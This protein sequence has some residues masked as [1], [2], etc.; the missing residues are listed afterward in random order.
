MIST[1]M[2]SSRTCQDELLFKYGSAKDTKLFPL[3]AWPAEAEAPTGCIDCDCFKGKSVRE[4]LC[5]SPADTPAYY[6]V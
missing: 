5:V 6:E 2:S 3:L 1:C 4:L